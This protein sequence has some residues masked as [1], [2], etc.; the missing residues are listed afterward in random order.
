M[1]NL[2]HHFPGKWHVRIKQNF[3]KCLMGYQRL[4]LECTSKWTKLWESCVMVALRSKL[5]LQCLLWKNL[6]SQSTWFGN[7]TFLAPIQAKLHISKVSYF[8]CHCT[9]EYAK[10]KE[11]NMTIFTKCY[12]ELLMTISNYLLNNRLV[13]YT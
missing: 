10:V 5:E 6:Y 8:A 13:F 12:G 7:P 9:N 3:S 11:K 4:Y 1:Y 2:P